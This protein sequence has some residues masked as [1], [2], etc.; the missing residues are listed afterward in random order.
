[1]MTLEEKIQKIEER[2]DAGSQ[3][4]AQLKA[5]QYAIKTALDTRTALFSNIH[6]R[7]KKLEMEVKKHELLLP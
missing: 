6:K 7:L 5:Q 3:L 4:F 2:L 1:M